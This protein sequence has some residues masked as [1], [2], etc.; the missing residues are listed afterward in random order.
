MAIRNPVHRKNVA[1]TP[2]AHE[3]RK[4]QVVV[5]AIAIIEGDHDVAARSLDQ[6]R[7]CR[8]GARY[9]IPASGRQLLLELVRPSR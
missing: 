5:V 6:I 7:E 8:P 9:P 2:W 1:G 3:D 4:G